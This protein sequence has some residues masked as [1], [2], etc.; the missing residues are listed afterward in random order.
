MPLIYKS[1]IMK[2]ELTAG[3]EKQ[4][5]QVNRYTYILYLILVIYLLLKGDIEWAAVNM[6]IAMVF[7]PFDARV[8]W[9][10]RPLYQRAWLIAHLT[11][12]FAGF[13]YQII[14]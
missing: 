4:S 11:L 1:T 10:D 7:D 2:Q 13:L 12:S 5:V 9:Q 8:K 14:R 3:E 6:G